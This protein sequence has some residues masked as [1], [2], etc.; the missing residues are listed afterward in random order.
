MG[1]PAEEAS[2]L[3]DMISRALGY[4]EVVV[5]ESEGPL[6]YRCAEIVRSQCNGDDPTAE[7]RERVRAEQS[8]FYGVEAPPQ[9]AA[10]FVLQWYLG[11]V[12]T[13]LAWAATLGPWVID[14]SPEAL[15]FD[16]SDPG[17]FPDVMSIQAD[18]IIEVANESDRLTDAHERYVAHARIFADSY[19]PPEVRMGSGQRSG[20]AF[21][22]WMMSLESARR[23]VFPA[24]RRL[25]PGR[26]KGCCMI[27]AL[28][29]ARACEACPRHKKADKS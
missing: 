29:G 12:A 26:R 13:P 9:V 4:V 15:S 20:I 3:A 8:S 22:V 21:D 5:A 23:A 25:P 11:V 6:R 2:R 7:W 17:C 1:V 19:R 24:Y 14:G 27:Y 10:A 16:L 18:R 28:P